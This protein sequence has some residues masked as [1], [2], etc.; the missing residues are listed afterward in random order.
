LLSFSRRNNLKYR[1]HYS[2]SST[3]S[4]AI[5]SIGHN[6]RCTYNITVSPTTRI[7]C[8]GFFIIFFATPKASAVA[9]NPLRVYVNRSD[10]YGFARIAAD[11]R[12]VGYDFEGYA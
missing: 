7:L 2:S 4:T 3:Q 5:Y 10:L 11:V 12:H 1:I 9:V 6:A 8:S